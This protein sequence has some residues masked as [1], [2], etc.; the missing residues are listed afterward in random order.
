MTDIRALQRSDMTALCALQA[1]CFDPP[2]SEAMLVARLEHPRSLNLG[3]FSDDRLLGFALFSF[4]FEEAE[5]L[6][7]GVAP[8]QQR[9]GLARKLLSQALQT[10][11]AGDVERVLLEVRDSN[12]AAIGLYR[13]LGF[14][15][16]GRRCGYYA[17]AGGPEDAVLMSC[18][19]G[20]HVTGDN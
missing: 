2:W 3:V 7:I 15:E 16:D 4:L 20:L 10:L 18:R 12:R 11:A 8:E 14:I 6:Q 17:G 5:V 1:Q 9:R 19:P 13:S